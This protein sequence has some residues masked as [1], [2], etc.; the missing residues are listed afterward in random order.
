[1]A[2]EVLTNA[3]HFSIVQKPKHDLESIFYVLLCFC[4]RYS[5]PR[6][7]KAV[8]KEELLLDKWYFANQ[9]YDSLATWKSGTLYEFENQVMRF[10]P[11]YFNNLKSCLYQLFDCV[12]TPHTYTTPEGKTRLLR[13]FNNNDATHAL[14]SKILEY[15]VTNLPDDDQWSPIPRPMRASGP[16][17]HRNIAFGFDNKNRS[18]RDRGSRKES[19]RKDGGISQASVQLSIGQDSGDAGPSG[20]GSHSNNQGGDPVIGQSGATGK[21][22][23][24]D[25]V[26]VMPSGGTAASTSSTSK[27][28]R[29]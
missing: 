25:P 7:I 21:Q 16:S 10:L 1:M 13:V 9:S 23:S 22:R 11:P 27:K 3:D 6:G 8:Y 28:C 4:F 26:T 15:I 18:S 17:S 12:F 19:G 2:I 14:M 29:L 20:A 5:G 24:V